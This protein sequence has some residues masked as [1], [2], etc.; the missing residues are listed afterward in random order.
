MTDEAQGHGGAPDIDPIDAAMMARCIELAR[1]GAAAG[2]LPIGSLIAR[3]GQIIA[4]STNEIM[5]LTDESRHAEIIAIARA[6]NLIGDDALSE[7]TLYS[8]VEPC[9]M[10]AFC[11]RA[12]GLG[13]VAFALG[14]PI[15]G[16]LSRWNILGDDRRFLFGRVPELLPGLLADEAHRVWIELRPIT[17]RA[18]WLVGFLSKPKMKAPGSTSS[19][20]RYRFSLR[21]LI[22]LFLRQYK[23]RPPAD[24][25]PDSAGK[26]LRHE[27]DARAPLAK[28]GELSGTLD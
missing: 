17:G 20:S 9:P 16:G 7:C 13:R 22:S 23:P 5:R 11:I 18:I 26:V 4:E 24:P 12:A 21:R 28:P 14:S 10:C 25:V 8:T 15:V 27:T 19:R 3:R 6:R 2:E 1:I